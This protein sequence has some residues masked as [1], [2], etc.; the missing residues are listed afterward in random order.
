MHQELTSQITKQFN[1]NFTYVVCIRLLQDLNQNLI[2][3]SGFY[4]DHT[5]CHQVWDAMFKDLVHKDSWSVYPVLLRP[6]SRGRVML[7]SSD[8]LTHPKI[9]HN[10][11]THP[12]DMKV[13]VEGKITRVFTVFTVPMKTLF[14]TL[15]NILWCNAVKLKILIWYLII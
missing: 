15:E 9:V 6:L 10:Y 2:L 3:K 11:F 5:M 1:D 12:H 8:A 14:P 4:I 7:K 13:M